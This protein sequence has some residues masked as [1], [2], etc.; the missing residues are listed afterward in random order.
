MEAAQPPKK[1]PQRKLKKQSSR[2]LKSVTSPARPQAVHHP[3]LR[4]LMTLHPT[5]TWT[6]TQVMKMSKGDD[7]AKK[8]T[9]KRR[10]AKKKKKAKK[11]AKKILAGGRFPSTKN[12]CYVMV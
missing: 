2:K 3:T 1:L 9:K 4:A 8:A 12:T 11:L 6:P 10:K 7:A 5:P